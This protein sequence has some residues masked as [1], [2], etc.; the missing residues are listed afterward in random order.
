MIA[1]GSLV[2]PNK[3]SDEFVGPTFG[4]SGYKSVN[5]FADDVYTRYQGF[6]DSA[7]QQVLKAESDGILR[8]PTGRRRNTVLGQHVD[9][10]ARAYMDMWLKSAG[11]SEGAGEMIQLNRWLRD[12]SGSSKYR[13]P[14]VF[15]PG[16]GNNG[17]ILDG[18]IGW[19]HSGTPQ[20]KALDNYS[21]GADT[22]I[23][24]FLGSE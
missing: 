8:L 18:T 21:N 10:H 5:D 3:I 7:Y 20:I 24:V 23:F 11:I 4:R 22:G 2:I 14:D 1:S 16:A 15:V 9:R 19:K 17:L 6:T 12:P 13:I